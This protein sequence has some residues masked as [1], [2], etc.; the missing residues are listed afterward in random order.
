[1]SYRKKSAHGSLG[2]RKTHPSSRGAGSRVGKEGHLL[3][4]G[5]K[6]DVSII[7]GKHWGSSQHGVFSKGIFE[8]CGSQHFSSMSGSLNVVHIVNVHTVEPA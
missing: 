1:M 2:G 8:S 7:C 6:K 5:R 4:P 3:K